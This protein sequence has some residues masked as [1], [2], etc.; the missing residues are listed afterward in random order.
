LIDAKVGKDYGKRKDKKNGM[1]DHEI[2][3][4]KKMVNVVKNV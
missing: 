4:P 1:M 3:H 2:R